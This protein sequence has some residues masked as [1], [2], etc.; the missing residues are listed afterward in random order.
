MCIR[1]SSKAFRSELNDALI[2]SCIEW[3]RIIIGVMPRS[4]VHGGS[5]MAEVA[6]YTDGYF[7]DHRKG[8]S[9]ESRIGA[10][11]FDR[12]RIRP[13]VFSKKCR[14]RSWTLGS[15]GQPRSLG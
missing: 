3:A 5:E 15:P 1:D 7:P 12:E 4:L 10:L 13:I 8:E 9:E 14:R 11:A 2:I 6:I